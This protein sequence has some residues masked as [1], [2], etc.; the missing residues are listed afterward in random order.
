M[1]NVTC[2]Q[3]KIGDVVIPFD[4]TVKIDDKE[5]K[6]NFNKETPL[7]RNVPFSDL[8]QKINYFLNNASGTLAFG[9]SNV[10]SANCNVLQLKDMVSRGK[11]SVFIKPNT[12]SLVSI[13][14]VSFFLWGGLVLFFRNTFIFFITKKRRFFTD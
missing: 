12:T 8:E 11:L 13:M 4:A 10:K 14:A 1:E 5:Y 9:A 6:I 2:D 3:K 7:D